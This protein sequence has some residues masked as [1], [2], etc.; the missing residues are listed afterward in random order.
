MSTSKWRKSS[1][2]KFLEL[3]CSGVIA[4]FEAEY[5]RRPTM[6]ELR[7]LLIKGRKK[8]YGMIGSKDCMHEKGKVVPLDGEDN[9]Q[10]RTL[11]L[12]PSC[13]EWMHCMTC[14]SSMLFWG[15]RI[16]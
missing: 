1:A 9:S 4:C 7:R 13:S 12:R 11:D 2:L 5:S 3:F 8:I 6:D 10:G 16:K 14:G 15:G